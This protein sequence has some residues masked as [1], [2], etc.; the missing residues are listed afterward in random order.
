MAITHTNIG[1]AEPST[2]TKV[3]AAV[4]IARGSTNEHQ[5]V[6]V[7]GDPQSSNGLAVVTNVAPAST[8]YALAV[9]QV[10][11]FGTSTD[12]FSTLATGTT[13]DASA[14]AVSKFGLQVTTKAGSTLTS[15]TV[16]LEGSIDS[17]NFAT[18][19]THSKGT[20]GDGGIVFSGANQF[21]VLQF[22]SRCTA[23]TQSTTTSTSAV[24][25]SIVGMV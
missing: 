16:V 2:V 21:P 17:T 3:V 15:W 14:Q 6:L 8:A 4:Q 19:L 23:F 9:R 24:I 18:L 25:A 20:D 5:E 1:L 7:L 10:P 11:A 22:R 12:T 13:I